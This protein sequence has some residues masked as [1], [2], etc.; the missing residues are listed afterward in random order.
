MVSAALLPHHVPFPAGGAAGGD[1]ENPVY[2]KGLGTQASA[3]V[4]AKAVLS[5][6]GQALEMKKVTDIA[7]QIHVG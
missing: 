4:H 6:L 5:I 1:P 7:N 2:M 3:L